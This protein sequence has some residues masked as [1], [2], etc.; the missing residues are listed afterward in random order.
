MASED[1]LVRISRALISVG[2]SLFSHGVSDALILYESSYRNQVDAN[3][4]NSYQG[5]PSTP[6]PKL[7]KNTKKKETA[8]IPNLYESPRPVSEMAN[9]IAITIQQVQQAAAEHIITLRR[10][11]RSMMK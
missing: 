9:T 5:T 6:I 8:T 10:P 3:R 7:A 11:Y 2:Y 4:E 1:P